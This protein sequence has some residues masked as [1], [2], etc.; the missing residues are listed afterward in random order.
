[1]EQGRN[2]IA[3]GAAAIALGMLLLAIVGCQTIGGASR[4]YTIR[5]RHIS[6]FRSYEDHAVRVGDEFFIADTEYSVKVE[7]LNPD[8]A[9]GMKT[10]EIVRRSG[11]LLNPALRLAVSY[12]A[13]PLY[14]TWILYQNLVPHEIPEPGFYF[15]FINYQNMSHAARK[16]EGY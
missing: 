6:D 1:V 5:V 10:K 9:I 12:Q 8:F 14:E 11:N 13:K 4:R 2:R 3:S 16:H 7:E 15:Q